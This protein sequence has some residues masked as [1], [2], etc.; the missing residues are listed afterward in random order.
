[1]K[2]EHP[3]GATVGEPR[4]FS[5]VVGHLPVVRRASGIR[6]GNRTPIDRVEFTCDRH[7]DE[8]NR[9]GRFDGMNATYFDH[10]CL[11]FA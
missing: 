10:W 8:M 11:T 4:Q 7:V 2:E 6:L 1:V 9:L 5:L 3:S